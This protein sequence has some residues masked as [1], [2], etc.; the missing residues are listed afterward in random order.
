MG[1]FLNEIQ[2]QASLQRPN[3]FNQILSELNEED[4]KDLIEAIANPSIFPS[5]I[6]KALRNRNISVDR[7]TIKRW[8]DTM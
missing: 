4:A 1:T 3:R 6:Q 2:Q 7:G 5:A 8:K